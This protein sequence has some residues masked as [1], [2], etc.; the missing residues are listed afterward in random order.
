ML[1]FSTLILPQSPDLQTSLNIFFK[2][3]RKKRN[4]NPD[5]SLILL[6][7]AFLYCSFQLYK[8]FSLT[9]CYGTNGV[10]LSN[11]QTSQLITA[12]AFGKR[13]QLILGEPSAGRQGTCALRSVSSIQGL[14]HNLCDEGQGLSQVWRWTIGGKEKCGN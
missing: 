7:S 3:K 5:S 2:E 9:F 14:G 11:A 12:S 10:L 13:S 4:K 6:P 8:Y 1:D